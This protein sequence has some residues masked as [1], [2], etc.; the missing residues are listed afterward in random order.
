VHASWTVS[1]RSLGQMHVTSF[2]CQTFLGSGHV[3]AGLITKQALSSVEHTESW[4]SV[5]IFNGQEQCITMG[6]CNQ[7]IEVS[8]VTSRCWVE[9]A[10]RTNMK[11]QQT[12]LSQISTS[13]STITL[14]PNAAWVPH[15]EQ[16]VALIHHQSSE[17]IARHDHQQ[18]KTAHSQEISLYACWH[19]SWKH[20]ET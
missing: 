6:L 2:L 10:M 14:L 7:H 1:P 4:H 9:R 18:G 3:A 12:C 17:V 11:Q 13:P 19:T 16:N 15:Q 20:G 8:C 5:L